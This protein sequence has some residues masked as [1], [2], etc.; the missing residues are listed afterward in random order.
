MR[1]QVG[2][3]VRSEAIQEHQR[4]LLLALAERVSPVAL[5]LREL[6]ELDACSNVEIEV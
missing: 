5:L 3:A 2:C 4:I 1:I 6:V